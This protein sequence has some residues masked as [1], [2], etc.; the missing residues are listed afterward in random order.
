MP[1]ALDKVT[2]KG[3][4]LVREFAAHQ[5]EA[6]RAYGEALERFGNG[7]LGVVDV[8]KTASDVYFNEVGRF[9]SGLAEAGATISELL[10]NAAGARV[11]KPGA[12][13]AA[14]QTKR[15]AKKAAKKTAHSKSV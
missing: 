10:L 12:K 8:V 11:L 9:A 13:T 5:G 2:E 1:E 6:Y 7:E 14:P 4:R 3:Q 15:T